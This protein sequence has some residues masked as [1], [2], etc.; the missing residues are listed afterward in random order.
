SPLWGFLYGWTL[1]LVIQTGTIAAVA[2]AFSP[3]FG[4]LTPS[5]SATTWII[6]PLNLSAGYPVSLLTL[7]LVAVLLIVLLSFINTRGLQLGKVIQN[8][9]TS[10]KTLSLIGLILL[11]LFIGRNSTALQAN[12]SDFWTPRGVTPIKPD[13]SFIAS[14][15]AVGSAFGL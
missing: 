9:F 15:S 2:V 8:I 3:F 14:V 5:I 7:Q 4:V 13:L 11:G 1:F 12:F 10:A 6:P